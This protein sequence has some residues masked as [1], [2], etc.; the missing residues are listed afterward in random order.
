M[1]DLTKKHLKKGGYNQEDIK[2]ALNIDDLGLVLKDI[3]YFYEVLSQNVKF[4]LFER[5]THVFSEASRVYQFKD[6]CSDDSI[7]EDDKVT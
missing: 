2:K 1:L 5:A 6:I 3:P 7:L 4:F